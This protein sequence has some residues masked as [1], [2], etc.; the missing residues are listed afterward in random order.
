MQTADFQQLPRRPQFRSLH[1]RRVGCV[2]VERP[3]DSP[4]V[5]IGPVGAQ[6][7]A[8]MPLV[9]RDDVVQTLTTDTANQSF[10]IWDG[11]RHRQVAKAAGKRLLPGPKATGPALDPTSEALLPGMV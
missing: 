2:Y 7:A 3:V 6:D 8:Q 1:W 9:Q 5:I 11:L 4:S 10:H